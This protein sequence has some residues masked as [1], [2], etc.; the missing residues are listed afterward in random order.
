MYGKMRKK[1][2]FLPKIFHSSFGGERGLIPERRLDTE[3]RKL[4]ILAF[5][6]PHP[7]PHQI[8]WIVLVTY[9]SVTSFL[10][11][12][13]RTQV[14][15][16]YKDSSSLKPR[17]QKEKEKINGNLEGS[18]KIECLFKTGN[19]GYGLYRSYA[20][21]MVRRHNKYWGWWM[22]EYATSRAIF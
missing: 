20:F 12:K 22:S 6:H 21:N 7:H 5:S 13:L 4:I 16:T 3:S 15:L 9:L 8:K 11:W 17:K 10:E 18:V 1:K 2:T 19:V 14:I